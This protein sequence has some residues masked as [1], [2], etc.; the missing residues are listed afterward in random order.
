MRENK[1]LLGTLVYPYIIVLLLISLFTCSDIYIDMNFNI[2]SLLTIII[3]LYIVVLICTIAKLMTN[4]SQKKE[5][6]EI[7]RL[8]MIIKL[9]HIPAYLI[10]YIVGLVCLL[11]L[12]TFGIS[13][14]LVFIDSMM[15]ILSGLVGLGGVIRSVQEGK[16][17]KQTGILFGV[18]QFMFCV[19]V[20]IAIVAYIMVRRKI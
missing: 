12:F 17:T 6:R 2:V 16:I 18:L 8:N 9:V 4:L 7:L 3:V 15:I 20:I 11:T 10:I 14:I 1:L 13:I 19:D 5:A